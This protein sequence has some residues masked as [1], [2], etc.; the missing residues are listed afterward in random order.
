VDNG[1]NN[2]SFFK[3]KQETWEQYDLKWC[4]HLKSVVWDISIQKALYNNFGNIT[5]LLTK[6]IS[7]SEPMKFRS[8]KEY[9]TVLVSL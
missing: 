2:N 5:L 6:F 4:E 8:T 1:Q 7:F 3:Q 9:L